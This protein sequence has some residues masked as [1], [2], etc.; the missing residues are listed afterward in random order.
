MKTQTKNMIPVR[1]LFNEEIRLTGITEFGLSWKDLVSG[2]STLPPAGACFD[3]SF[4]GVV[5]GPS[6]E[7]VKKG[8]DHLEVRADG[9]FILNLYAVITSSS[10]DSIS[11]QETGVLIPAPDGSAIGKLRLNMRLHSHSAGYNWLNTIE[12]WGDGYIDMLQGSGSVNAFILE[13]EG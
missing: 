3:V 5:S 6:I 11:V 4:E 13:D 7:G 9:K 1:F 10:G 12:V 8:V 2:K